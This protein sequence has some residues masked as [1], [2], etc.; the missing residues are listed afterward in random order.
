MISHGSHGAYSLEATCK[1]GHT[2]LHI[3]E[4]NRGKE[5][6]SNAKPGCMRVVAV[7]FLAR[8]EHAGVFLDHMEGCQ[9]LHCI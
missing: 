2:I 6:T 9:I 3:H 5:L 8:H 1:L 7:Q 4:Q